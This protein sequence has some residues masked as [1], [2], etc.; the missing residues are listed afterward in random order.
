M[1]PSARVSSVRDRDAR[2]FGKAHLTDGNPE[3]CWASDVVHRERERELNCEG[4]GEGGRRGRGLR[5]GGALWG[6]VGGRD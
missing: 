1:L 4:E 5:G 2:Q 6:R 3:T